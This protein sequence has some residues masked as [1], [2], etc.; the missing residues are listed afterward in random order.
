MRDDRMDNENVVMISASSGSSSIPHQWF[1]YDQTDSDPLYSEFVSLKMLGLWGLVRAA[2]RLRGKKGLRVHLNHANVA[3]LT[4]L[5]VGGKAKYVLSLH[6]DVGFETQRNRLMLDMVTRLG[7]E[8]LISNS[9]HT[10]S[11]IPAAMRRRQRNIVVYNGVNERI[12]AETAENIDTDRS[13]PRHRLIYVGR[14]ESIKN[15]VGAVRLAGL[16]VPRLPATLEVIGD[17]SDQDALRAIAV[18]TDCPV[19]F[20]GALP[21]KDAMR[22][23]AMS[24]TVLIPSLSEGYCNV[25]AEA[26]FLGRKIVYNAIPT[27]VEVIGDRGLAIDFDDPDMDAVMDYLR[28]DEPVAGLDNHTFEATLQSFSELLACSH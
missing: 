9:E 3:L 25:G 7:V 22:A 19:T 11:S 5:L 23:L 26:M 1:Q 20:R 15:P 16:I 14:L 2:L 24:D 6:R 12:L 17:G 10:R 13:D 4:R 18:E 27:L 21:H 28:N 8:A